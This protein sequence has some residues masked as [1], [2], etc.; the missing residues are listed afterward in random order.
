MIYCYRVL[1][2]N[3]NETDEVIELTLPS[4]EMKREITTRDG[5]R[6]VVDVRAQQGLSRGGNHGYPYWSDAFFANPE[7][8]EKWRDHYRSKGVRD[9]EYNKEGQLRVRSAAHRR[10][11]MKAN[12]Y[13]DFNSYI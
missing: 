1:D 13:V 6:A 5:R 11:L 4:K 2:E 7:V 8:Q 12:G 3:G 9:I 10:A